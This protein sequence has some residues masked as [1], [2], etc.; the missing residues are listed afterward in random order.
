MSNIQVKRFIDINAD[1]GEGLNNEALLM[2]FLSSC[3][4]ACGGHAGNE[5]SMLTV[6][7]LAKEHRVKIGAHPS[8]PDT[9]NFGR[10]QM[11]LPLEALLESL[12]TQVNALS[13]IINTGNETLHHIKPHGALY[14]L[15]NTDKAYA[16]VI[17][18]LIKHYDNSV[19]LYAPYDSV[20][21]KM[22]EKNGVKIVF[23]AFADRNYNDDLTL[24]LR[25]QPHALIE[26]DL[27]MRDHVLNMVLNSRVKTINGIEKHIKADTICIHG[28]HPQAVHHLQTLTEQLKQKN[29]QI[30]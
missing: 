1:V 11:D 5:T 28:D 14:N 29:I 25:S 13:K 23:E 6:M 8:F 10:L 17:I 9:A 22:A 7:K 15:A 30:F 16:E 3:N 12:K 27:Q 26:E 20:M 21:A 18:S 24:V 4:I 2:P 19:K